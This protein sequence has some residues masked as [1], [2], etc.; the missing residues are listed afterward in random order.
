[1][2]EKN[3][4]KENGRAMLKILLLIFIA[5][6]IFIIV[7]LG[8]TGISEKNIPENEKKSKNNSTQVNKLQENSNNLARTIIIDGFKFTVPDDINGGF[9]I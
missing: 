6:S 5:S 1:M 3:L 7:V 9:S 8:M 4:K 2:E